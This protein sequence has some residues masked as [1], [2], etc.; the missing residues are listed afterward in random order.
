MHRRQSA[1]RLP[2]GAGIALRIGIAAG[3]FAEH[4]EAVAHPLVPLAS[5]Q[6][7]S[8]ILTQHE[9]LAQQRDGAT[10]RG[11][12][13]AGSEPCPES[14]H[15]PLGGIGA[16]LVGQQ[17]AHQIDRSAR[18][19]AHLATFGSRRNMA[20]EMPLFELIGSKLGSGIEIRHP[21]QRLG[22]PHQRQPFGRGQR[23][24]QQ[25]RLQRPERRRMRPGS[26]DPGGGP[27]HHPA[28][29]EPVVQTGREGRD[30]VSLVPNRRRQPVQS[31]RRSGSGIHRSEL[32]RLP[33]IRTQAPVRPALCQLPRILP[34]ISTFSTRWAVPLPESD[35]RSF[36]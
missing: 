5:P 28:P 13:A 24:L 29:I 16:G 22:Q 10:G 34:T 2:V 32:L 21:Q 25:Q 9:L 8:Q 17:P 4:V 26:L 27:C 23:K 30:Q 15:Q 19:P 7:L 1:N 33:G 31:V 35:D 20:G 3:A 6:R 18:Q 11:D 12:H 14:M 36:D